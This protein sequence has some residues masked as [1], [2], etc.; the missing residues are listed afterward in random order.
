MTTAKVVYTV[1]GISHTI[2]YTIRA[3]TMASCHYLAAIE[4]SFD[5]YL[6]IRANHNSRIHAAPPPLLLIW[7]DLLQIC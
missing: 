7:P 1:H 4:C 6:I 3:F 5:K 2:E